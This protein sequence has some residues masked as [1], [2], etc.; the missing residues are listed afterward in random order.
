V[1]ARSTVFCGPLALGN[2]G[3][4]LQEP[5][6]GRNVGFFL[7]ALEPKGKFPIQGNQ[8]GDVEV[9]R[10]AGEEVRVTV[11]EHISE[12]ETAR[13]DGG[14]ID[15]G[16]GEGAGGEGDGSGFA[17]GDDG[18][19]IGVRMRPDFGVPQEGHDRH[20]IVNALGEEG[21]IVSVSVTRELARI[22]DD[23]GLRDVLAALKEKVG[24]DHGGPP[25][26]KFCHFVILQR[27]YAGVTEPDDNAAVPVLRDNARER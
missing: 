25:G 27:A 9:L 4:L 21:V 13:L 5:I 16:S 6:H 15:C 12:A 22:L 18:D 17:A 10:S 7:F 20:D 26:N 1:L 14:A 8:A 11:V 3:S 23:P 2:T 24:S 19:M